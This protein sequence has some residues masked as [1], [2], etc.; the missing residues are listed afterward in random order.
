MAHYYFDSSA[1]V[2]NYV[3]EGGTEWVRSLCTSSNHTIY[4]VRISGAEIAAAFYLRVRTNSIAEEDG[5][6]AIHQFK[7]DFQTRYQI[8]EVTEALVNSAI[9]LIAKHGLRGYDSIQ[10]AAALTLHQI[11]DSMA[12]PPLTFVCSDTRLNEAAIVERLA[13]ENPNLI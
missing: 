7:T 5:Q 12:L 3:L 11:R 9:I 13:V 4:T 10:L 6:R 8:V 2:K 1:L